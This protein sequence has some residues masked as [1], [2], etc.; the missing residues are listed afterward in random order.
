V[1]ADDVDDGCGALSGADFC[2]ATNVQVSEKSVGNI[3]RTFLEFKISISAIHFAVFCHE[4]CRLLS[5]GNKKY[6]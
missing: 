4:Y 1:C 6:V 5:F 2:N 3:C